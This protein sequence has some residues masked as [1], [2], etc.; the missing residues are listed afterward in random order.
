M[1]SNFPPPERIGDVGLQR[2]L[3]ERGIDYNL[4]M[5]LVGPDPDNPRVS[6]RRLAREI[7]PPRVYAESTIKRW[8]DQMKKELPQ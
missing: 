2:W 5:V 7:N 3:T 6:R 8:L 1:P 4:L